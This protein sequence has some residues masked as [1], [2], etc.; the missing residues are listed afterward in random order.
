MTLTIDAQ[1]LSPREPE[2]SWLR[3]LAT[4]HGVD[5]K[6][7]AEPDIVAEAFCRKLTEWHSTELRKR[8]WR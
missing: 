5:P 4:A 3:Q 7:K 1:G 2:R 6:L 8:G